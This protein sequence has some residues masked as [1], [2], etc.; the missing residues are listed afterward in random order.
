LEQVWA[1]AR[2]RHLSLKTEDAY[3]ARFKQFI[4]FHK[5]WHPLELGAAEVREY[6]SH[7]VVNQQVAAST[8]NVALC[9]LLFLYRDVFLQKD[10]QDIT[11][12]E[13]ARAKPKLPVVFTR[14]EVAAVFAH[15]EGIDRLMTSIQNQVSKA[16]SLP[17]SAP[18]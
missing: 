18:V 14:E 7:L 3:V 9:A 11:G 12:V 6:L 5:K 2:V 4:L 13:R 17:I 10:L 8:Q 15:L 1:V 16:G